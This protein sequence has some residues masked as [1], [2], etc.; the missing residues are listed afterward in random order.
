MSWGQ[1]EV[2]AVFLEINSEKK[3][4]KSEG[5]RRPTLSSF[6]MIDPHIPT[7]KKWKGTEDIL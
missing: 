3:K 1:G 2:L 5:R 4:P 7:L 6:Q